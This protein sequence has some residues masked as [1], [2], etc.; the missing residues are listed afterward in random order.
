MTTIRPAGAADEAAWRPLWQGYLDFYG[1]TLM[2]DQT[3]L[4]WKRM[5]DPD[6]PMGCILAFDGD[7]RALGFAT[8]IL[9][10]STWAQHH[11][12]YL[13]DLFVSEDARGQGAGR[14]LI[15]AVA[16]VARDTG[17][18]RLYWE[19]RQGNAQGRALYDRLATLT[20]F[21]QYRMA[22]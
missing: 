10:R 15:E 5:L 3:A 12:C 4:T 8:Y 19:T 22:L 18:G 14:A 13:E 16:S 6:E 7:G 21:I 9:H 1:A 2:A 11:Y 17:A 20:D